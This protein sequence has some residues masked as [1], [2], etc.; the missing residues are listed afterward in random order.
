MSKVREMIFA[1]FSS[2]MYTLTEKQVLAQDY[3]RRCGSIRLGD[4]NLQTLTRLREPLRLRPDSS[5][6]GGLTGESI[7]STLAS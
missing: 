5:Q 1:S 7:Y 2:K 6:G 4:L 3:E